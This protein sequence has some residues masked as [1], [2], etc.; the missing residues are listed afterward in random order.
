LTNSVNENPKFIHDCE[1]CVFLGRYFSKTWEEEV[2]LY[3]CPN[4]VLG[5]TIIVRFGDDGPDYGSGLVFCNSS[6][7]YAEACRRAINNGHL[8]ENTLWPGMPEYK[9]TREE[10]KQMIEDGVPLK[11]VLRTHKPTLAELMDKYFGEGEWRTP[12]TGA[13]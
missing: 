12:K 6:D 2:D 9:Y 3:V 7:H 8:D 1:A 10:Q 5:A 13:A 4:S 11:E